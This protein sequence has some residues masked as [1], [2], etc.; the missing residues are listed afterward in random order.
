MVS[1]LVLTAVVGLTMTEDTTTTTE[2]ATIEMETGAET[3]A[4]EGQEV[5][6]VDMAGTKVG[7]IGIRTD[8]TTGTEGVTMGTGAGEDSTGT[9]PETIPIRIDMIAD[10]VMM[11]TINNPKVMSCIHSFHCLQVLK[12]LCFGALYRNFSGSSQCW[13][14]VYKLQEVE[15]VL[16]IFV[17]FR[18][19]YTFA[20]VEGDSESLSSGA[21]PPRKRLELKPRTVADPPASMPKAAENRPSSIFGNAKPVDTAQREQELA[22]KRAEKSEYRRNQCHRF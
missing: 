5:T 19:S 22:A 9:T 14:L 12:C 16:I 6:T 18:F 4:V 17:F 7:T 21:L 15:I 13:I 2:I 11:D 10:L 1:G 20:I 8:E 3:A